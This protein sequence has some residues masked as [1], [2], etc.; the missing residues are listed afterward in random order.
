[1]K[2]VG[3]CGSKENFLT[4][5]NDDYAPFAQKKKELE[6]KFSDKT[7][8]NKAIEKLKMELQLDYNKHYE[9]NIYERITDPGN[10]SE[11]ACIKFFE[12]IEPIDHVRERYPIH[13]VN[14]QEIAI[15]FNSTLKFAFFMRR[16]Y[17]QDK[18]NYTLQIAFKG[19]PEQLIDR[20]KT[21]M[22]NGKE[23]VID[24]TFMDEF[25]FA[26]KAFALKGE[27]VI[28]F[29]YKKLDPIKF[30]KDTEFTFTSED[31]SKL[32]INDLT[33]AGL[34]SME[35][36]PRPGVK[37]AIQTCNEA[38]V[39]VIMVTGDQA[40][41]AASIAFQ[42]G[43]IKN[44]DDTPEIIME[45]EGLKSLEEAEKKS[46]TIIITGDRIAK[47]LKDEEELSEDNPKKGALLRSWIMKRD[48]VFARTSPQHKLA[49]V[50]ACQRLSH[51]V[52][53]TGDGVNDSPAMKKAD[54]GVAMGKVGTDVA[55]DAADI[56]LLDDNFAN[57]VRGIKQGRVVFDI[58]K[59][60]IRYNLSS[61]YAELVPFIGFVILQFPLPLTTL[62]LL[63]MDVGTNIY[64]NICFAYEIA[65]DN[66]MKR[67]PRNV[68]TDRLCP[69]I[70][71]SYGYLF[72]GTVQ[73][74]GVFL[75]YFAAAN[76]YGLPP[77]VLFFLVNE[78]G[79]NPGLLDVFNPYDEA[80]RGNSNA[81]LS[82]YSD[83]L[84]FSGAA[85]DI[86]VT[87]K[88]RAMDYTSNGDEAIDMRLFYQ[89]VPLSKFGRCVFDS[90]GQHYDG[91]VCYRIEAIRHAQAG[92]L[93]GHIIMQIINGVSSRVKLESV[94]KHR[95]S[96]WPMN[97]GYFIEIIVI[98]ILLYVP[99]LNSAF[100]VRALRFEHW[101]PCLGMFIVFLAYDEFTRLLIRTVKKPDGSPGFF[102]DYFNY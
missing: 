19:A 84:G 25:K 30:N 86:M 11:A 68:K 67:Q 27:R 65:E 26:N 3:V 98:L 71:F 52:A 41:T 78:K 92:Y 62:Q 43:I 82:N 50:D 5:V 69:I 72:I 6:K 29:A 17:N 47:M 97:W 102:Y 20:C 59:K 35:D 94:F 42:I 40:L 45:R 44:L 37:E 63:C 99:G 54:I 4:A 21:Y 66:I 53:V 33:F 74:A 88:V 38:G 60:I 93:L 87:S 15:P 22:K 24:A 39:K 7:E 90:V 61:N 36:P 9:E 91:P 75:M 81:F 8:L 34:I 79:I 83:L 76:D 12:H 46:N 100:Q 73:T 14:N 10:A 64:P 101:V 49:I 16:I 48:V 89:D 96:N 57:I 18:S 23:K 58:L 13:S 95:F 55:K 31:L 85:Y 2:F 80:Y 28:G 56:L 32:P 77:N 70:L 51:C 1:M